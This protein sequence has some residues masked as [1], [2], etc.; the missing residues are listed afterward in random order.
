MVRQGRMQPL[1][2]VPSAPPSDAGDCEA[3]LNML[4]GPP[5]GWQ[6]GARVVQYALSDSGDADVQTWIRLEDG[7]VLN[8]TLAANVRSAQTVCNAGLRS[9]LHEATAQAQTTLWNVNQCGC[10]HQS[11]LCRK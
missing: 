9:A 5:P 3:V 10:A 6:H 7:T 2:P 8:D 11:W 1:C 4:A